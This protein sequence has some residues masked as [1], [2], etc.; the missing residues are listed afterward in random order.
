MPDLH[1]EFPFSP[2]TQVLVTYGNQ[3]LSAPRPADVYGGL[4]KGS[5]ICL[6]IL[7][8][9]LGG[10]Y[11]NFGVFELYGDPALND[12]LDMAVRLALN[13]PLADILAY[14]KVWGVEGGGGEK[15]AFGSV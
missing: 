9:A 13:I 3:V 11:V 8:R 10:S 15:E 12:A 2:P 14:R 1:T 4:Y 5:W 7:S 6:S